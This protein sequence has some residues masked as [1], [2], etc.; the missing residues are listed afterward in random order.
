MEDNGKHFSFEEGCLLLKQAK[1]KYKY[2][3]CEVPFHTKQGRFDLQCYKEFRIFI[4]TLY[5]ET[6]QLNSH[7][8]TINQIADKFSSNDKLKFNPITAQHNFEQLAKKVIPELTL[9]VASLHLVLVK[10]K[11]AMMKN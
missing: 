11:E 1:Y 6:V 5:E 2:D 7:S 10:I 9:Y 8:N 3:N 4:E